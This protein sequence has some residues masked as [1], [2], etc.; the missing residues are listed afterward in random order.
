MPAKKI[1]WGW[2]AFEELTPNL[3]D[4]LSALIDHEGFHAR[5]YVENPF[6]ILS[7]FGVV[8]EINTRLLSKQNE[9]RAY[10][11]NLERAKKETAQE[12]F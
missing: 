11:Y 2:G 6:L 8:P 9:V 1:S 5:E 10:S 4:F 3:D 7:L 12:L